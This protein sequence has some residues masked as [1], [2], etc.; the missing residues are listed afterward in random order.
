M[1]ESVKNHYLE[2][3]FGAIGDYT[4]RG[5]T[6]IDKTHVATCGVHKDSYRKQPRMTQDWDDV[7]CKNCLRHH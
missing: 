7:D 4:K 1:T 6:V 5:F 2:E 3:R